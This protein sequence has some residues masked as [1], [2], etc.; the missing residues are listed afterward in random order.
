[1]YVHRLETNWIRLTFVTTDKIFL[2]SFLNAAALGTNKNI[3]VISGYVT[4][5]DYKHS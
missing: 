3:I 1:M 5:S 4:E 2:V